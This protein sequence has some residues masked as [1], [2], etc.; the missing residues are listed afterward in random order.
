[1]TSGNRRA[2]DFAASPL[3][4]VAA[5]GASGRGRGRSRPLAAGLPRLTRGS[6][7]RRAVAS[8]AAMVRLWHDRARQRRTLIALSEHLLRDIGLAREK[9]HLEAAKPFCRA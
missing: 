5:L 3:S 2:I 4:S 7:P 9:A 8:I 6:D 1:M